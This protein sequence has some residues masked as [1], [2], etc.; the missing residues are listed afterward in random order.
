MQ[1]HPLAALAPVADQLDAQL[2][3]DEVDRAE[4]GD[5]RV[6]GH[7]HAERDLVGDL[8]RRLERD[9][10]V[11]LG[12]RRARLDGARIAS[13]ARARADGCRARRTAPARG[14]APS[15]RTRPSVCT[16]SR[17]R[18]PDEVSARLPADPR[19]AT[20]LEH[21]DGQ[22]REEAGRSAGGHDEDGLGR[23]RADPRRLLG[24]ERPVGDPRPHPVEPEA[25]A[26]RRAARAPPRPRRRS[27]APDRARAGR[28]APAAPPAPRARAPRCR[29][30][31]GAKAR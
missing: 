21:R 12:R 5:E 28:R 9:L 3:A 6:G 19:R 4:P 2:G 20:T 25:R 11:Q 22:R 14:P 7:A 18:S 27:S 17:A 30:T 26:A 15:P 13:R 1:P 24:G 23:G 31:I 10:A 29:A 16:P 8:E